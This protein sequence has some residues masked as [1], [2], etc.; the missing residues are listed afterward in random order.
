RENVKID[1]LGASLIAVGVSV[2]LV[3][4]SFVDASF[5]WLSWQTF[6][7]V[8]ASVVL[9]GA[10]IAVEARAAEPVV[11][12]R[13]VK[14]RTTALA[15]LVSVAVGMA[16]FGGAVFLGQY[17]QIGRGYSPTEAGLLTIPMMAGVLGASIVSG[18]LI[19]KTGKVKPYIVAGAA[20]LVVGFFALGQIDHQTSLVLVGGAMLLV[21]AGVGMSMQNLVLA[22]QNT[23]PLKDIGAASSTIAFFRSLG[24]TVGVS[25][26]GAVLARRVES[27]IVRDLTAA[28]I[29]ASGSGGG[30]LNLNVLPDAVQHIIRAAYGDATGH[31]FLIS[32]AIAV[33]GVVA[34]LLLKPITLR[35]SLDLAEQ[36]PKV[37]ADS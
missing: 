9:L 25:V 20:T 4:I 16:M 34:A 5:A 11:P 29:P 30:S 27:A 13:I 26:L 31:I 15:I 2:L 10:A 37:G 17:F 22:V 14:Q 21:G 18:R 32:A 28:G 7:M 3:W 33:I 12:L 6:A 8:G 35:T 19:T 23:V 1:Y 24:G 36:Q